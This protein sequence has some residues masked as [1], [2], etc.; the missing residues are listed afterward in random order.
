MKRII[1]RILGIILILVLCYQQFSYADVVVTYDTIDYIMPIILLIGFIGIIVLMITAIS[2]F[3][4][5]ASVKKQNIS[6]YNDI[7]AEKKKKDKIERRFYIGSII[8]SITGLIYLLYN[9][10]IEISVFCIP[11]VLLI[12]SFIIRLLKEKKI[13][14]IICEVT[15][16]LVCIMALW[17][18]P[19]RII[20]ENYNKQF[21]QYIE[22]N[23]W[24]ERYYT[25]D[26]EGLLN[27]AIQNNKSDRK[28]TFI[29]Q[30]TNYTS[31]D[32]LMQLLNELDINKSY[33][34]ENEYNTDSYIE[35]ITLSTYTNGWEIPLISY[36]G[37]QITS[38]VA[39]SSLISQAR[40]LVSSLRDSKIINII[41]M[42]EIDQTVTIQLNYNN[43]SSQEIINFQNEFMNTAGTYKVEVQSDPSNLDECN[44]II[45]S[46]NL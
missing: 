28:V 37:E 25:S 16:V 15:V 11:I 24:C 44:L 7:L 23:K 12:I 39:K 1:K 5:K 4:L 31:V 36:E 27:S 43:V 30:D 32:E 35:S 10:Y 40:S 21:Q 41:Y 2:F 20:R 3:C 22:Y 46:T 42:P 33:S 14:N 34:I 8:L 6:S 9:R 38:Y 18:V 26:V 19:P 17:N 45:T 13:S 29:Y